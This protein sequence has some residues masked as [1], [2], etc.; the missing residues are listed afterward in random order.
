MHY[1]NMSDDASASLLFGPN[2]Q[3][4]RQTKPYLKTPQ[5]ISGS[6]NF[7]AFSGIPI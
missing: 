7:D 4:H 2:L 1:I 5:W 6:E 3:N